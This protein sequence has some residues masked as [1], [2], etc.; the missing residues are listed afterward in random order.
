MVT[1]AGRLLQREIGDDSV[2][3]VGGGEGRTHA[4]LNVCR[5]RGARLIEDAEGSVRRRVQWAYHAWSYGLDGGKPRRHH[6]DGVEDFDPSCWGLIPVRVATVG[7]LVLVDLS[8][9][10]PD[11]EP[12]RRRAG[13]LPGPLPGGR[14]A[15]GR[16]GGVPVGGELEGD[17]RELQRV[18]A[19][20]SRR[21]P[22]NWDEA[23]N[24][25]SGEGSR[26]RA[27]GAAAR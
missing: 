24:Y 22:R 10:A 5:H 1:D 16:E 19:L 2:V 7:G 26:A 18:S 23:S 9:E 15:P 13:R 25:M 17:R 8:G 20:F 27:P 11:V 6:M 12:A 14:A 4:F 21:P 3:V